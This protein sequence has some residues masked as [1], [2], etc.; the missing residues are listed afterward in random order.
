M[1]TTQSP[2][3][4]GLNAKY[5]ALLAVILLGA[6]AAIFVAQQIIAYRDYPFDTDEVFHAN[7]GS[8]LALDLRAGD[9][10]AFAA[11]S[12]RRSAYPPAFSWLE[13]PVFL[14][15]G[16]SPFVARMCS[17]ACL[18]AAALIIYALGLELERF[19]WLIGLVSVRLT[20]TAQTILTYS[21]MAVW[22]AAAC[23]AYLVITRRW[24]LFAKALALYARF[25]LA[26]V[27]L[28]QVMT[29]GAFFQNLVISNLEA[30][31][32]GRWQAAIERVWAMYPLAILAGVVTLVL[33]LR[34]RWP[35][36]PAL[37]L[38]FAW[39]SSVTTGKIGAYINHLL[40][41]NIATWLA[42]GLL[43]GWAER[44]KRLLWSLLA[45]AALLGQVAMMVHLPFSIQSGVLPPWTALRPIVQPWLKSSRASYLWT[46][47]QAD[48]QSADALDQRV[49]QTT[50][51]ILSEDSSFSASHGRPM[52]IQIQPFTQLALAGKW[53][54][55]PFL[56]QI[57]S[58]QFDLILL[59]FDIQDDVLAQRPSLMTPEMIDAIRSSYVLEQK[60]WFYNVYVPRK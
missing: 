18:L 30:W 48:R 29:N 47:A 55:T 46:P 32:F 51:L 36:L 54:Q 40:E 50:G 27:G 45:S 7:G 41:A 43:L 44:S 59:Q 19:G 17:L 14:I 38:A 20:L 42:C 10:G 2:R 53:D 37:Y 33:A 60:L 6:L 28:L 35:A 16:A 31:K 8:M 23:L 11:D 21:A 1:S 25:G 34:R 26:L 9:L 52:W 39:V 24:A 3:Y 49:R 4:F 5:A 12:Y 13:A 56:N 58:H 57:R 15:A 22:A